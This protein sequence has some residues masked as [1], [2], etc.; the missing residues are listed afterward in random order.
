MTEKTGQKIRSSEKSGILLV[1]TGPSGVGKDSVIGEFLK[2]NA[3]FKKIVTDTSRPPRS[4]EI[5][6]VDY[7]FF[8]EQEFLKKA[9]SGDYLEYVEVR[10]REYKG[11]PKAAVEQILSGEKV[12]WKIDEYAAAHLK[13]TLS[14]QLPKEAP[15][16]VAGTVVVYVAPEEWKQLREQYF[17]RESEANKAWFRV[18]LRRDKRMWAEYHA[19]FDHVV[20]NKRQKLLDTVKEIEKI[21]ADR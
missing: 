6:G 15:G 17:E 19:C 11:T 14:K 13:T 18:K 5:E 7:K 20:I 21:I 1:I 8:S 2:R 4:G 9:D 16:I 3:G 10:P 12:I